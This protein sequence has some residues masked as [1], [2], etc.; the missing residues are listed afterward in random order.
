MQDDLVGLSSLQPHCYISQSTARKTR[1][2][3][4]LYPTIY[5]SVQAFPPKARGMRRRSWLEGELW[6]RRGVV[7][8]PV[9]HEAEG[10]SVSKLRKKQNLKQPEEEEKQAMQITSSVEGLKGAV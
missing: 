7:P 9:D 5:Q 2:R 3:T 4:H 6:D 10:K 1:K 8:V